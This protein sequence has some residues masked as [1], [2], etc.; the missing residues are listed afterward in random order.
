MRSLCRSNWV[1]C[2]LEY[3]E[4]WMCL[5]SPRCP[6]NVSSVPRA[7]VTGSSGAFVRCRFSPFCK[8]A[9]RVTVS[10]AAS[11]HGGIE[12]NSSFTGAGTHEAMRWWHLVSSSSLTWG[13]C[14]MTCRKDVRRGCQMVPLSP[15]N[16]FHHYY[17]QVLWRKAV[18]HQLLLSGP[19]S[20]LV[21]EGQKFWIKSSL[22]SWPR[23]VLF[24]FVVFLHITVNLRICLYSS[25]LIQGVMIS[26]R[27]PPCCS[28]A[29]PLC[30]I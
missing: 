14:Q 26:T 17:L 18:L 4:F 8:D 5:L 13:S 16:P 12:L 30:V 19:C 10:V 23:R 20:T 6:L 24:I 21:P 25:S 22:S 7:A 28:S 29:L 27:G 11:H 1:N 3:R 15:H 2:S 9:V